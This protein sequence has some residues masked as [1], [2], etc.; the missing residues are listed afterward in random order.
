MEN[1]HQTETASTAATTAVSTVQKAPLAI[2]DRGVALA[3][4]EDLWRFSGIVLKSGLAPKGLQTQ[5]AIVIAIEMGMEVGLT[6]LCALQNIAVINGR[7]SI[8]GDAQLAIVRGT[9]ELEAFE[10]W[11][12]QGGTRLAR[13]PTTYSE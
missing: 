1:E 6:P 5:E 3:T 8:W 10:E 13:Y 9:G 7:P 2:G 12:E 4:L 11:Y